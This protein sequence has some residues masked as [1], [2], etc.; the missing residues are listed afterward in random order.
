[1]NI[2]FKKFCDFIKWQIPSSWE[3]AVLI[4]NTSNDDVFDL[5]IEKETIP[6]IKDVES[7]FY[8]V[9]QI[10]KNYQKEHSF[11]ISLKLDFK[12]NCFSAEEFL[13]Y[14]NFLMKLITN[15]RNFF[16]RCEIIENRCA[17]FSIFIFNKDQYEEFLKYEPIF[18]NKGEKFGLKNLK[19]N[20]IFEDRP[21]VFTPPPQSTHI[22]K[23]FAETTK[24][25]KKRTINS[26]KLE[27]FESIK[28]EEIRTYPEPFVTFTGQVYKI[29]SGKTKNNKFRYNLFIVDGFYKEAV[30]IDYFNL[31]KPLDINEN[32]Y[33]QVWAEIV[34]PKN[35]Y[36]EIIELK[37]RKIK[38]IEKPKDFSLNLVDDAI[39]K[40]V[41]LTA[42]TS[43]STMDGISSPADY[44]KIAKQFGHT[45][46]GIADLDS[47]QAFPDFYKEIKKS[48]IKAI[49]GST[50][51]T[52]SSQIKK[53]LNLNED[54]NLLK[55]RYVVLDLE[56]TGLSPE[57]S[58][59]IEFGAVVVENNEIVEE[60]QF[61]VNPGVEIPSKITTI[62]NITQQI[63]DEQGISKS[64]AFRKISNIIKDS[65]MVAH[66]AKF[67]FKFLQKLFINE[68]KT[69]I[70]TPIIDTLE[71]ARFLLPS[72]KSHSLKNVSKTIGVIYDETVAHRA[73]YDAK[74]L[75]QVW[76][77][78]LQQFVEQKVSTLSSLQNQKS[79]IFEL[80]PDRVFSKELTVIAKNQAGLKKLYKMIS[81][82]NTD[83]LIANK[84]LL[85]YDKLEK[86]SDLIIGTGGPNSQIFEFLL[87]GLK[88]EVEEIIDIYDFIELPPP[89][90]FIHL[91]K[92]EIVK[93][94]HIY[95]ALSYLVSLGKK[96]NK[97]VVAVGDVRYCEPRE[98][99]FHELYIYAKGV[100]GSAHPLFD[101]RD[102]DKNS[103]IFPDKYFFNTQELIDQFSFLNNSELVF[104]IVVKNSNLIAN[105]IDN[106]IEIIKENLYPPKIEN[107]SQKLRDFA[108]EVAHKKYGNPLPQ[109]ILD[110][111]KKELDPIIQQGFDVVYWISKQLV[112]EAK[113]E[114]SIVD[115]RGSV[116]SSI[117]AYL[118][119]I[120]DVNPLKP[121]YVCL[122]CQYVEFSEAPEILC[123]FDL[124]SK[125][126]PNCGQP[127]D[128][129]GQNIPFETFLGFN[130]EKVPDIDLNFAGDIQLKMHN[131]IRKIFGEKNTFRAGT[132]LT[133]AEKTVFGYARN[134]G[135]IKSQINKRFDSNLELSYF[136]N[137]F[138]DFL[139]TKASGV[140]RTSG[141]HAG[142]IVVIPNDYEI[143]DFTP[144]N[145]PAN[146]EKSDWKTTHFDYKPMQ[147]NI[148]KFDILGHDDPVILL[149]LE[150]L[151]NLKAEQIPKNDPKILE[152]FKS[153]KSLKIQPSQIA[154]E[155]T[156]A[157]GI[158]EF[159]THFVR[160]MLLTAPVS[161]IADIIAICGLA[162]GTNVWQGNAESLITKENL[163]IKD[164]ISCRDDIMLYLINKGLAS[165]DAFEIMEQVRKGKGINANQEKL[166]IE[167][168]VPNWYIDSLQK[169]SYLFPKAHAAA[170]VAKAWKLAFFKLYYPL[171]FYAVYFS[172]RSNTK[173]ID[174]MILNP[175]QL[176]PIVRD[177]KERMK[178]K[179]ATKKEEDLCYMLEIVMELKARGFEIQK[180]DLYRSEATEWQIDYENN[181]LIPPFSSLD[182][183]GD[184]NAINIVKARKEKPF[185]SIEDFVKRTETNQT[186]TQ[187]LT[188]MGVFG[189][190]SKKDQINIFE[191]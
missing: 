27:D 108:Y 71:V 19:I 28:L 151:T 14:S 11:K 92:R 55:S 79:T 54:F 36:K 39:E 172:I 65:V 7:L 154:G 114:G 171:A 148:L 106:N 59:I 131:F 44:V 94:E 38:V 85:F 25:S 63:I 33:V 80:K 110:R 31:S 30:K 135:E 177:L 43:K 133:S 127:L 166:L 56:T 158:P 164:V 161:S 118:V 41:E 150:K 70:L 167:K 40:R 15:E 117:V 22:V 184:V 89:I 163:T 155:T 124:P 84:P 182:G 104:E 168:D 180:I 66:N 156:G 78:F 119:G 9:M 144:V 162:H 32:D 74:V 126:C 159:G 13:E 122:K 99:I 62:T 16:Q 77:S 181:A 96:Y 138:M 111:I 175:R 49:Y 51:S 191:L 142:G 107:S 86:D 18:L 102:K 121:H 189:T 165:Y 143:E 81:I 42:R 125:N 72:L 61:F 149:M 146:D 174:K 160:G 132:V 68:G 58:E 183:I 5:T 93:E 137:T 97:P 190:L 1:M 188:E 34:D 29:N 152:L 21:E 139:S 103:H 178:I 23:P 17:E 26:K 24:S 98:K 129:D 69:K 48:N 76:Q 57:Y 10:N 91:I 170:Y 113:K 53:V 47:V 115:S 12:Q 153:T 105:Q 2:A 4:Q 46:I 100:G 185:K 186:I 35:I 187:K 176:E 95:D 140:K 20:V 52:I 145:Y 123:G 169:I 130:A 60:H 147:N 8:L 64:E 87:Y 88:E 120:T 116:G 45:A 82:A 3:D 141:R 67:D 179:K 112:E 134:L 6:K 90:A 136:T 37:P 128:R 101:Y 73:D 157:M 173:D 109:L 83:N 50:F 75:A